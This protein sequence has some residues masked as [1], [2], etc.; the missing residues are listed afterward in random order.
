MLNLATAYKVIV[1]D[2]HNVSVTPFSSDPVVIGTFK[3][4]GSFIGRKKGYSIKKVLHSAVCS[5]IDHA[6]TGEE[7]ATMP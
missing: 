2:V 6:N 3:E 7:V 5:V 4:C 1:G